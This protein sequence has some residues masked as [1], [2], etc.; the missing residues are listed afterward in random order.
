M[1]TLAP[2]FLALGTSIIAVTTATAGARGA[3]KGTVPLTPYLIA[4]AVAILF[5][6]AAAVLYYS[7]D[8][9]PNVAPVRYD[10][11]PPGTPKN[12]VGHSGLVVA[13]D[14]DPAYEVHLV[15]RKVGKS[16]PEFWNRIQRL[17][18]QWRGIHSNQHA[19][20]G[21]ERLARRAV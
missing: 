18:K 14:G 1:K 21:C 6:L 15:S 13:N 16:T 7:H 5:F 11:S 20:S 10:K 9:K 8:E 12:L 17:E 3:F 4:Y 2:V 19:T